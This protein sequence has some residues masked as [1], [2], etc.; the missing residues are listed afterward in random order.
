MP[1]GTIDAA[2]AAIAE[3]KKINVAPYAQEELAQA[4]SALQTALDQFGKHNE[5][6]ARSF[7]TRAKERAEA[8][9]QKAREKQSATPV[10]T[11]STPAA[12]TAVKPV[13]PPSPSA[14][15]VPSKMRKEKKGKTNTPR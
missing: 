2:K 9:L 5:F 1:Q 11:P 6:E 15:A 7:A 3:A 8:A 12:G 4:E 14:T 13:T 10:S